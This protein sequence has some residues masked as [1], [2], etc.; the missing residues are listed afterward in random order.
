[1]RGNLDQ[2]NA[3]LERLR[4]SQNSDQDMQVRS[5]T[6]ALAQNNCGPQYVA[7]ARNQGGGFLDNL[8][9][10]NATSPDLG[11]P[12]STYRTV[13]VRSCDGYYFPISFAT[14]PSR[15]GDDDKACKSL[16]PAADAN[17]YSYRNP[18]EDINSAVSLN[19]QPYSA[20]ANAFKYR[21][22]FSPTCS[23]RAAGQSWADALKPIDDS[24]NIQQGD[25]VVT[26]E[27]AKAM[28]QRDAQGRPIRTPATKGAPAAAS[29]T[30]TSPTP[31]ANTKPPGDR[32]IRTVGPTFLPNA[33]Q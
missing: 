24:A 3:N 7:A 19:G 13:C 32:P 12:A 16:C 14:V 6:Q 4:G 1:M 21:R 25:I 10:P 17:L 30:T 33:K 22:E 5:V 15:F 2:I 23:C 28:Q 20:L 29:N 27:S 11:A 31:P 9:N 18:G 8:F 26:E